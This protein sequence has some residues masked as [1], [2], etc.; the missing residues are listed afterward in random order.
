[1]I[2]KHTKL[3]LLFKYHHIYAEDLI[4]D[5][6]KSRR[7]VIFPFNRPEKIHCPNQFNIL[8][9]HDFNF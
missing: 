5:I 1:M 6:S 7:K 2:K 3:G 4:F 9:D 8:R